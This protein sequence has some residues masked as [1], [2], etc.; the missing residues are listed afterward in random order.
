MLRV[1][2]TDN[3]FRFKY[4][5]GEAVKYP[6]TTR[7]WV[8]VSTVSTDQA[9]ISD[10]DIW[11]DNSAHVPNK[12][13]PGKEYIEFHTCPHYRFPDSFGLMFMCVCTALILMMVAML[14]MDY[15]FAYYGR[16]VATSPSG[17]FVVRSDGLSNRF[18]TRLFIVE[19]GVFTHTVPISQ[20]LREDFR[21][22]IHITDEGVLYGTDKHS[23]TR[24][25]AYTFL[26]HVPQ[27]LNAKDVTLLS[28][29]T[30]EDQRIT[31]LTSP[32]DEYSV[33]FDKTDCSLTFKRT[34]S[35][36]ASIK[37]L[38]PHL[39]CDRLV[40]QK[41]NNLVAYDKDN[42]PVWATDTGGVHG[43]E[44]GEGEAELAMTDEGHLVLRW[45]NTNN[46]IKYILPY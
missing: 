43:N 20:R 31:E 28:D 6:R 38:I 25:I 23:L 24:D 18:N 14:C 2:I 15:G 29:L 4:A 45:K 32:N 36:Y 40:M 33:K 9:R 13:T 37:Y 16:T 27:D 41:D 21:L 44:H 3:H 12:T 17:Y 39:P 46:I 34:N 7:G 35:I 8:S 1:R 42:K 19:N 30:K 10:K 11:F 26:L 5:D 22:K